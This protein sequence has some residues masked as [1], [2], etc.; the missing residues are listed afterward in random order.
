[1]DTTP[2][3]TDASEATMRDA[4]SRDAHGPKELAEGIS[5]V[6]RSLTRLQFV[7]WCL[8]ALYFVSSFVLIQGRHPV[9]GDELYPQSTAWS[10]VH[11]GPPTMSVNGLFPQDIPLERF[12]GPVSFQVAVALIRLF[13]LNM[14]IWRA[15]CFL[16]GISLVTASA[17]L[18]LRLSGASHWV[19][20]AGASTVLVVTGYCIISP[21]RWDPVTVGFI[22]AGITFLFYAAN[23]SAARLAFLAALAG[24]SFGLA[25]GSTP[26]AL[27]ALAG[28]VCAVI[29]A[30][31]VDTIK[32]KRILSAGAVAAISGFIADALLL[33]PLGMTPWSWLQ[34]VRRLSKGDQLDSS[35][36]LG[37][38]WNPEFSINKA[39]T[40]VTVFLLISGVLCVWRQR[41]E[42]GQSGADVE[43]RAYSHGSGYLRSVCSFRLPSSHLCHFLAAVS[44]GGIV[45]LDS[46]GVSRRQSL[47]LSIATLVCLELLLPA[48]LEIRR[49]HASAK[50]WQGRDPQI[51]LTQIRSNIPPGSIVFGPSGGFFYPVE[52]TGSRYLYLENEITPGLE[53]GDE[54][55]PYLE[56]AV[57]AAACTAPTFAISSR[58][59]G[60][61]SFLDVIAQHVKFARIADAGSGSNA[62]LIYHFAVPEDCSSID[63]DVSS[64]KPF[65]HP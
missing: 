13:G 63:F 20:L 28:V 35:P 26:R 29:S 27:P 61:D 38:A 22:F 14:L 51:A 21:G 31:C 48:T 34:S 45:F 58:E 62:P 9:W 39:A 42:Q 17:A 59:D 32:M 40:L 49:M 46:L 36:L 10:T 37:G 50:L 5:P 53:F 18:L 44:G 47:P 3:L 41:R 12:F 7:G 64:I 11:G 1:M 25:A 19:V 16:F 23:G 43:R 57:D 56:R 8:L 52:E 6:S 54:T 65:S 4:P 15:V 30:A 2:N 24:V 60:A 33:A 55:P